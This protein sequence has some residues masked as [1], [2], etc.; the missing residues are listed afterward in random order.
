MVIHHSQIQLI[1]KSR[2][3]L[4][5]LRLRDV[6]QKLGRSEA[7]VHRCEAGKIPP[8]PKEAR[9]WARLL[10]CPVGEIFPEKTV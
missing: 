6:A 1:R 10:R 5:G 2:R 7:Y 8:K 3:I 4:Q 9:T